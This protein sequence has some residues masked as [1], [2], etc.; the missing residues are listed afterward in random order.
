MVVRTNPQCI[1]RKVQP[2]VYINYTKGRNNIIIPNGWLIRS[3]VSRDIG[4]SKLAI[5]IN[6]KGIKFSLVARPT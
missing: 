5:V 6:V 3:Q 2:L 1:G 4:I